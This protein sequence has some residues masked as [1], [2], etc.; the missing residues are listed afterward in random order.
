MKL[1]IP[2]LQIKQLWTCMPV[3]VMFLPALMITGWLFTDTLMNDLWLYHTTWDFI[4]KNKKKYVWIRNTKNQT[5]AKF[6]FVH[7]IQETMRLGTRISNINDLCSKSN[8]SSSIFGG[9]LILQT[10]IASA[11]TFTA[12]L[13]AF[14][15]WGKIKCHELYACKISCT[16][17]VHTFFKYTNS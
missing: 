15:L 9:R 11:A 13:E 17:I 16:C 6:N 1:Q 5:N 2:Q 12:Y 8:S 3:N 4:I 14:Y 7:S 10:H